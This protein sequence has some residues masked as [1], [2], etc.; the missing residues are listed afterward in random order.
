MASS[1][2]GYIIDQ[3]LSP[4]DSKP[5]VAILTLK[6]SNRKTGDM[7][8]VWILRSGINPVDALNTG[9]D[10]SICGSC[11]HRKQSDGSRSCYVNVGQAPNSVYKTFKRGGYAVATSSELKRVL[12]GRRVRW[13]AYG[14]PAILHES[15]VSEINGYV[16]GHTGYTHQWRESF[17]DWTKGVFQASCDGMVDYLEASQRGYKTFAVI[18]KGSRNYSGKQCPA[19]IELS[20]AQCKTCTLCDGAKSDIYVEAHGSGAKYVVAA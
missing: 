2:L 4:I 15:V 10:V 20:E 7:A 9:E 17:A 11:P 19:T 3:G 18:P 13:G 6:S 1:K 16:L 14:D 5:Y 12:K 8:Q